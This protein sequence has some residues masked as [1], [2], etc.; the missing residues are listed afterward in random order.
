MPSQGYAI[1]DPAGSYL[2]EKA[3]VHRKLTCPPFRNRIIS[4]SIAARSNIN[5]GAKTTATSI[6]FIEQ[7]YLSN[8]L[9]MAW[10]TTMKTKKFAITLFALSLAG[11][12]LSDAEKIKA[13]KDL[14]LSD[15]SRDGLQI[16]AK[17]IQESFVCF[18]RAEMRCKENGL[19]SDCYDF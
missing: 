17:D 6:F 18:D 19:R 2:M 15:T 9:E 5:I 1:Y 14:C 11:C 3:H 13:E 10:G 16:D 12:S 8:R 7:T 4:Y